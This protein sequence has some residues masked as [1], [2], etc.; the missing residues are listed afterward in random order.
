[1]AKEFNDRLDVLDGDT[2]ITISLNG[3]RAAVYAGGNGKAGSMRLKDDAGKERVSVEAHGAITIRNSDAEAFFEIDGTT[4]SLT[5]R[6]SDGRRV[7]RFI[8]NRG[9]VDLGTTGNAGR[10]SIYDDQGKVVIQQDGDTASFS[11]G[12]EGRGAWL[13]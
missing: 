5:Y 1:M 12:A 11:L 8:S 9:T 6:D 2:D 3:N 13:S 7:L 10:L 4:G